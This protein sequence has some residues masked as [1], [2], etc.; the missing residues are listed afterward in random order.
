MLVIAD[1][2]GGLSGKHGPGGPRQDDPGV[3]EEGQPALTCSDTHRRDPA[4]PP[5]GFPVRGF[6]V[7]TEKGFYNIHVSHNPSPSCHFRRDKSPRPPSL[8]ASTST[9][10]RCLMDR[11]PDTNR[12][13]SHTLARTS[14]YCVALMKI[15]PVLQRGGADKGRPACLRWWQNSF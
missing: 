12:S 9:P 5:D 4:A 8:S 7:L 3:Q 15:T 10:A 1:L 14:R 2:P 13:T 11:V 6:G